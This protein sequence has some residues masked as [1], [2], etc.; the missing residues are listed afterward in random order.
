MYLGHGDS[1]AGRCLVRSSKELPLL[2]EP[3]ARIVSMVEHYGTVFVATQR[4]VYRLH[5]GVFHPVLFVS[6]SRGRI[7]HVP[8]DNETPKC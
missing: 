2:P 8:P 4:R 7:D 6:Q 3:D 1:G 5:E